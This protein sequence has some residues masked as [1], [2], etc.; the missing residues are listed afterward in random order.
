MS[1]VSMY[2]SNY[3]ISTSVATVFMGLA[4]PV[5][6]AQSEANT[7]TC[8]FNEVPGVVEGG[9]YHNAS[10]NE[11]FSVHGSVHGSENW[12]LTLTLSEQRRDEY[13]ISS[14]GSSSDVPILNY[15]LSVPETYLDA[16]AEEEA[17][18]YVCIYPISGRNYSSD[19]GGE[20]LRN[21]LAFSSYGC[22]GVLSDE[23][24]SALGSMNPPSAGSRTCPLQSDE[25][26]E[27]CGFG[28]NFRPGKFSEA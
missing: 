13:N 19:G 17:T 11:S 10:A 24:L 7:T 3:H 20:E 27:A 28:P 1:L 6:F 5:V 4:A 2:A 18:T 22:S 21:N 14:W 25:A 26:T 12:R 15:L 9:F 8:G 23:C 16:S